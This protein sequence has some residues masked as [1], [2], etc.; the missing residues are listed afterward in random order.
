MTLQDGLTDGEAEA[1]A[2]RAAAYFREL[3]E[4]IVARLEEVDGK[5]FHED[6]W[7]RDTGGGGRTRVLAEGLVFEKAGVAFSE[8]FGE[9]KPA[10][11]SQLP[12]EGPRFHA[13]GVSLIFHPRNP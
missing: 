10:F 3:Q 8:V 5:R 2:G 4:R 7:V 1:L 12:G 6:A 13:T 9:L 11:A